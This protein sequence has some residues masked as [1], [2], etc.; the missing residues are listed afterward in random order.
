MSDLVLQGNLKRLRKYNGYTQKQLG[1]YLGITRQ[2]YAHYELGDRVP[3]YV[4]LAKL[5]E[6]YKV[7]VDEL[8]S[9][10]EETSRL[11]KEEME[12]PYRY[13]PERERRLI[14]MLQE[15]PEEEQEDLI[16]YLK[17]KVGR[18][19]ERED[20]KSGRG[21]EMEGKGGSSAKKR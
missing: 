15:L 18:N 6:F 14:E 11:K 20:R 4:V 9:S 3:N 19:K 12:S 7:S 21:N 17:R 1:D 16:I 13:L 8:L 2:A 5:A 10:E